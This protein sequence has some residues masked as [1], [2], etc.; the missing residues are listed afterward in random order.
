VEADEVDSLAFAMFRHLQQVDDSEEAGFAR[1]LR[2]DVREADWLDGID[3]DLALFH[4]IAGSDFDVGARP[5][6]DAAGDFSAA[7]SVAE[8][9]REHHYESL[10][11]TAAGGLPARQYSILI[12]G[13]VLR[14]CPR[15]V[16]A[17]S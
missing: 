1:Q 5:D 13:Y 2:R 10:H 17:R 6:A 15:N 16:S 12:M 7:N 4:L 14:N 11:R 8:A 9:L 3:F